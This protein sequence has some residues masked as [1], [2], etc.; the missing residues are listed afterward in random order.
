MS[1]IIEARITKYHGRVSASYLDYLKGNNLETL[2]TEKAEEIAENF[3]VHM[4]SEAPVDEVLTFFSITRN[5]DIEE[6]RKKNYKI[7]SNI[8]EVH[9]GKKVIVIDLE[10]TIER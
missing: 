6:I 7:S 1:D 5:S 8:K 3:R 2:S 9:E 10:L 4:E